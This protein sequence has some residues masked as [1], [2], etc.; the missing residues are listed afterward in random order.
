[1]ADPENAD[2][3]VIDRHAHDIAVRKVYGQSDRG[4]GALGRYNLLADCYRAAAQKIGE[5]PSK[6]QAVTWVAHIEREVTQPHS[7]IQ[8]ET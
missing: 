5:I 1:M 3:V 6:V 4:L 7:R 2:P 8:L